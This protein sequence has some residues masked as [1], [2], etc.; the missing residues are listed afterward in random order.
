MIMPDFTM[1]WRWPQWTLLAIMHLQFAYRS[2][3]HGKPML[4]TSGDEK[5]Q[6]ERYNGFAAISVFM[7]WIAILICGGFFV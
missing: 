6:P 7:V 3:R 2:Y 5:G 1:H 4:Q